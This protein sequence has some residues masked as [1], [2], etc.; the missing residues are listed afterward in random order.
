MVIKEKESQ[1]QKSILDYLRLKRIFCF[2]M[3]TTGIFKKDTG[4]YIP[5][6]NVGA[7]DIFAFIPAGK[8]TPDNTSYCRA[9]ALEVKRPKNTQSLSQIEWQ[10]KFEDAGGIYLIVRSIDDIMNV[11]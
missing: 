11:L 8:I 9:Y 6:Q 2:K 4:S 1:I 10:K 7:P 5:S 3:N